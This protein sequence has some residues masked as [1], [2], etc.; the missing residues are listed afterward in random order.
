MKKQFAAVERIVARLRAV[1]V[2]DT[3]LRNELSVLREDLE[4]WLERARATNALFNYLADAEN[5][6]NRRRFNALE[7]IEDVKSQ[8]EVLSR[9]IPIATDRVD[10][11]LRLPSGTLAEW[12]SIF[13]NVFVNAF[14]AL[15]DAKTKLIA[16][17]SRRRRDTYEILVQDTGPGVDLDDSES[18]FEPF[19]RR[20]KLSPERQAL[21]YG[22]TGLGLTI[23]RLISDNLGCRVAFVEPEGGFKTAFSI[24]WVERA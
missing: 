7:T 15:I 22:G 24:S 14:N 23:V 21:G 9:E 17:S 8:V 20:I 2:A 12:S 13:Q 6:K 19:E 10:S 1:K 11:T 5:V 3:A 4:A 18:L 16:V